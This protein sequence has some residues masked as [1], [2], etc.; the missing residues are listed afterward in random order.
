MIAH[1]P[2]AF[3]QAAPPL[4]RLL[5]AKEYPMTSTSKTS[6]NGRQP[7]MALTPNQSDPIFKAEQL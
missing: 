1:L 6:H 7:E 4:G 2:A 5:T 3:T